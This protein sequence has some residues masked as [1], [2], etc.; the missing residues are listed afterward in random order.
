MVHE[1][2]SRSVTLEQLYTAEGSR[3]LDR[4]AIEGG[5]PGIDLMRRAGRA[6]FD[7]LLDGW[8]RLRRLSICC[9][10][11]NNAGDGYVVAELALAAG[12]EV[13]LIQLGDPGLLSGD[14]ATA[15]DDALSAGVRIIASEDGGVSPS[16]EVV[17]DALLGTGIKGPPRAPFARM[18]D[19]MNEYGRPVIAVDIPSGVAADTG[20][21]AGAAVRAHTTVTFI[22]R[23]I[24]LYTGQG[25]ALAGRRHF[26]SLGVGADVHARVEGLNWLTFAELAESPGLPVRTAEAYKQALG[27]VVVVGGDHS[28]GGAVAMAAEAALRVGAGMVTVVT[29]PEHRNAILARRPEIMVLDSEDAELVDE[30]FGKASVFVLGPGLGRRQWGQRLFAK[31][32]QQHKP[33]VIDADGLFWLARSTLGTGV[34]SGQHTIVTPHAAEAAA[35]LGTT[36]ESVQAD[37][38]GSARDLAERVGGVAVLKGAGTVIANA[39]AIQ[40]DEIPSDRCV[41]ICAH[42]N[43]GMASA[44]MGDVLSGMIGGLLGQGSPPAAAAALGTCLHSMAA[45]RAAESLGQAS[46]LATDL[47]PAVIELL[48]ARETESWRRR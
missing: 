48:K 25:V 32:V 7:L 46:L 45:D 19:A 28:M 1:Q 24:G 20:A 42:G 17:V 29:R 21:A 10:R 23:K 2:D 27:H 37:R 3:R 6:V 8:P 33:T 13:E 9:G 18:I 44:G 41:G 39:D 22:G 36:V 16:G 38:P 40:T 11:G 34:G 15:R 5:Q 43:P 30:V 4:I 14:A 35:L 26:V 12:F 31:T 47:M